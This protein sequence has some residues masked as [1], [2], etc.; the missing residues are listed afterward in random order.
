MSISNQT[1]PSLP[2]DSPTL[3]M[4]RVLGRI[5]WVGYLCGQQFKNTG[6]P[7]PFQLN[8]GRVARQGFSSASA[9]V[10][11]NKGYL[12][13]VVVHNTEQDREACSCAAGVLYGWKEAG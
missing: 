5:G 11:A 13:P 12:G 9:R 1:P 10:V 4:Q 7:Q 8:R 6:R 2:D 3:P